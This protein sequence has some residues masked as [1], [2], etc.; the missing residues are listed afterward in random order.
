[1]PAAGFGA[2]PEQISRRLPPGI[3]RLHSPVAQ[4]AAGRV[5]GEAARA[6]VVATAPPAAGRLLPGLPVPAM[7]G[8]TTHYYLAPEA[9]VTEP[10]IALDGERSG[11]VANALELTSAAPS[12][13]PGRHLVQAS[14][15]RGDAGEPAV[16]AH[17]ARIYG[18]D[19]AGWQHVTTYA[20]PDGVPDQRPPQGRLRKPVRLEP[21]LYVCGDH[22]DSGSLQGALV[23]GRRAAH[24]VLEDLGHPTRSSS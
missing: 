3:L 17:L 12:Y 19:T 10:A 21:G 11:P 14:V 7:N 22:R 20:I 15:V 9:P 4:V 1:V 16:R 23:S 6:V 13:A 5:D 18:A 24:A 8:V 2:F